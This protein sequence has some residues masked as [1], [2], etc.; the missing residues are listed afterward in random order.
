MQWIRYTAEQRQWAI[1]QMG[2]PSNRRIRAL[3]L[4]SGIT[5]VTLRPW[6]NAAL[7]EESLVRKDSGQ[8]HGCPLGA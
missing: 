1:E 7:I 8:A 6:R 4:A 3:V 5:E 2:P